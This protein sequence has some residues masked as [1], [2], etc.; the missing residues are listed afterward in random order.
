VI[1]VNKK[2]PSRMSEIY[3]C[4]FKLKQGDKFAPEFYGEVTSLID[5]LKVHPPAV[6]DAADID[7]VS[8]SRGVK[9]FC[10]A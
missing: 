7:G 1:Y 4:L 6:T 10:L 2:N 9:S 5:E 8:R 3:E